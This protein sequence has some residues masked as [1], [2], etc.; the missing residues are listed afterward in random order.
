VA[1]SLSPDGQTLA[2][3][4][5]DRTI[6]LWRTSDGGLI[7]TLTGSAFA[8]SCIAFAPSGLT[9]AGSEDGYGQNVHVWRVSDGA[10]IQTFAGDPN[11]FTDAVAWSPS[12]NTL[13]SSSGYTHEVRFWRASDGF[14]QQMYDL[15]T[16]W[17]PSP[18]LPLATSPNG[19][20][21]LMGRGDATLVLAQNPLP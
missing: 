17:G 5:I 11:G 18:V 15:E 19:A 4:S 2:S 6:R 16:G 13:L 9:I 20:Y 14:L 7:R 10:M 21:F 8:I 1:L 12:G 3:G